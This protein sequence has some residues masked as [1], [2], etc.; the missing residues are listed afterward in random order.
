VHLLSFALWTSAG[1]GAYLVTRGVCDGRVL[2]RYRRV[3]R[4]QALATLGATGF[5]MAYT[6]GLPG[7]AKAAALLYGPLTVLEMLHMSATES[8]TKLRRRV[9]ALT[10]LWSLLLAAI[11]YLKLYKPAL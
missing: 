2:G 9:D 10:P 5:S 6:L 1:L 7:W 11:L 8:C 3:A 4:L